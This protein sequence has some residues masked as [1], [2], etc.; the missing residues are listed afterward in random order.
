MIGYVKCCDSYKTMYF[1]INVNKLS[2][3]Y[4]KIWERVNNLMNIEFDSQ[5]VFGDTDKHI[6]TKKMY[7]DK[8]NTTFQGNFFT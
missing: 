8:V 7:E 6:K 4:I 5:P 2:K 1:V 3:K